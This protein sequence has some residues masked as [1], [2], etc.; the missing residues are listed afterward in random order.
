M[1][2]P[3]GSYPKT[4][5]TSALSFPF[6]L[7]L[8]RCGP[9]LPV[10][11]C[12]NLMTR[13]SS[14][15]HYTWMR[16]IFTRPARSPLHSCPQHWAQPPGLHV[17]NGQALQRLLTVYVWIPYKTR[18]TLHSYVLISSPSFSATR[19]SISQ[20]SS[21]SYVMSHPGVSLP[22][23]LCLSKWH[24]PFKVQLGWNLFHAST[25]VHIFSLSMIFRWNLSYNLLLS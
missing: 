1:A 20:F 24:L 15:I 19:S 10:T 12:E 5:P 13:L 16:G 23:Y 2:K 7:L 6:S 8:S 21:L 18:V 11:H 17:F 3:H 22:S 4:H 25:W 9:S 14:V